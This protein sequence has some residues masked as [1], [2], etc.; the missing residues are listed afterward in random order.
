[1]DS[2]TSR[3]KALSLMGVCAIMLTSSL[4]I[5]VGSAITPALPD[6]AREYALPQSLS[7]W[8][9]TLPALGVI[10][11]ALYFGHLVDRKG[12]YRVCMFGLLAYGVFGVGGMLMP[13]IY[14]LVVIRLLL[15]V[16]AAAVMTSS[17]AF[18]SDFFHGHKRMRMIAVQGMAIELGGIIFLSLGGFLAEMS[19]YGPFFIYGIA[20]IALMWIWMF[21]PKD[22]DCVL[23]DE[24]GDDHKDN[25]SKGSV[26]PVILLSFL[27]MFIFFSGI[28]VLPSHLQ[29]TLGYSQSFTGNYLAFISLIAVILAGC[30]PKVVKAISAKYTLL[31]AFF[32]FG[33]AF[34]IY[35]QHIS[36]ALL[37]VAALLMGIGFGLTIPLLNNLTIERSPAEVRGRNIGLYSMATFGGQFLSS[38]VSSVS[39][40]QA[41]FGITVIIVLLTIVYALSFFRNK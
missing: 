13:E 30:M 35:Y 17:T 19:W 41:S 20:F 7:G 22:K 8:L 36:L 28:V 10:L 18:I 32:S 40:G 34:Y 24:Q 23:I 14:S 9:V 6:I 37:M 39:E 31:V 3:K 33:C 27:A 12:A 29:E 21:V 38:I 4:T 11:T 1:M 26:I 15:G 25:V 16:A 5:M 2:I